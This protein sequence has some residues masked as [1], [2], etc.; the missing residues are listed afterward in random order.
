MNRS[1]KPRFQFTIGHLP[2][3]VLPTTGIKPK[4]GKDIGAEGLPMFKQAKAEE[5][6]REQAKQEN[7]FQEAVNKAP[8]PAPSP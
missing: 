5:S 7:F 3:P 1:N 2:K 6:A 8:T 4:R